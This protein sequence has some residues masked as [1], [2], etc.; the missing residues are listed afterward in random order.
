MCDRET[1]MKTAKLLLEIRQDIPEWAGFV[2]DAYEETLA[3]GYEKDKAR[4]MIVEQLAVI[5]PEET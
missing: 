4:Q 1:Y 2:I 5:F 3:L